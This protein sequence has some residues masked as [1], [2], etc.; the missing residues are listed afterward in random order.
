MDALVNTVK[1]KLDAGATV[2]GTAVTSPSPQIMRM[3]IECGFDW[4]MIDLEHGP[5]GPESMQAM[6]NATHGTDCM[7]FVRLPAAEKWMAKLPLDCG[8]MGLFFPLIMDAEEA[9]RA[10]KSAMYPPQGYRGFGP[11]HASYRWNRTMVEYA[12]GVDDAILKI[13]MI[14]HIEAVDQLEKI[15]RVEGIDLIFIAPYD[16]SQSLGLPGQFEHRLV[17][18]AITPAEQMVKSAGLKLGGYASTV[19]DGRKLLDRGYDLV[20]LGYDGKLVEDGIKPLVNG[21]ARLTAGS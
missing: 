3:L 20:M 2:I 15:V 19:D 4:L 12:T 13:I 17:L 21:L 8:A 9:Q 16:L 5:I 7:P 18:K 11:I 14:E 6:I 10:V 1:L